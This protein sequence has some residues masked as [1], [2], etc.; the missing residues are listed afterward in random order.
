MTIYSFAVL[1]YLFGT[2]LLFHLTSCKMPAGWITSWNQD[3]WEKYQQLQ[4]YRWYHFNA[5]TWRGTKEPLDE[6]ER[7]WKSWLK[8]QH[9]KNEDH[10]IWS[11]LLHGKNVETVSDF[12]FLGSKITGNGDCSHKIKRCL[13]LGRTAMTNLDCVLKSRDIILPT[14][15]CIVKFWFFQ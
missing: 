6:C 7:E 2:S 13:L 4:I 15:F 14:E 9:S 5:R 8:I 10:G 1:L 3:F 11:P 12:I